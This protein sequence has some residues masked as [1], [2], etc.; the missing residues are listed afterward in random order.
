MRFKEVKKI[1]SESEQAEQLL[2]VNM[3]PSNLAKLASQIDARAGM[4]FEMIVPNAEGGDDSGEFEPDYDQ[5]ESVG[6]ID[7]A[8]NFFYDG[9]YNSR[10]DIDRLRES[11]LEDYMS[12]VYEKIEDDWGNNGF[13]FFT[14]YLQREDPF[15]DE[16][17]EEEARNELRAEYGDTLDDEDFEKMLFALVDEK[18]EAY[19]QTQWEDQGRNYDYAREEFESEK[20]DDYEQSD[21][22]DDQGY[23]AMS[24]ISDNYDIQWPHFTSVGGGGREV[25]DVADSFSRAIGRPV[26]SSTSYHGARRE[27]GTYVVEPDGSLSG[28]NSGDAGLEFVSPPL[29]LAELL[30]DLKKVKK[31][32]DSEGCY[33][34]ASNGTGLHINVSVPNLAKN[35]DNLDYVK[36]AL[37]LGDE[38]VLKEF[39][40]LGNTYCKSGLAIVKQNI[41]QKPED[42]KALLDQMKSNLEDLAS[43]SIHSGITNKFT[44][45]NTKDGY[46]E[47]RSPGGDWLNEK[48]DKI[49]PT[50]LRFV[51]ALDAA[52]K[53]DLYRQEYLK[54]LYKVLAPSGDKS[55]IEYF[56]K[57]VAG[58][59]PKAALRSFV[60]QAQLERKIKAGKAEGKMWWNVKYN[61]QRME[62]VATNKK[63]AK[64]VAAK[65]WGLTDAQA[66]S[67]SS[68]DVV[69]LRPYEDETQKQ[70]I[71]VAGRPNNPEGNWYLKNADTDKIFYRF[72]AINYQDAHTVLQQWKQE[73]PDS[74]INAVYGQGRDE[75]AGQEPAQAE[76]K[77]GIW[78]TRD[79]HWVENGNGLI[80][81]DNPYAV[82]EYMNNHNLTSVNY[83]M[84][85]IPSQQAQQTAVN[86]PPEGG[87]GEGLR[88]NWGFWMAN[89]GRFANWPGEGNGLRRFS[90]R[91]VAQQWLDDARAQN[92]RMR[93]DIEV[94]EIEP[95]EPIPGSTLDLQRQRAA[96]AQ[97]QTPAQGGGFTGEWKVVGPEGNEIYRFSGVGNNQSDANA[98]A[99]RWLQQNPR[100]LQ[101]GVE[102]LPVMG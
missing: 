9:D 20:Q 27:E 26:N 15:D 44:S 91:E 2:E 3:S 89:A 53:P 56:A 45:I 73:N 70:G 93:S 72:N 28:D 57:Y 58:E 102:V 51:V 6:D 97:Q 79:N 32:A 36:L 23:R 67:I 8:C 50:L 47:F 90:S 100:H 38:H 42:A 59:I 16:E 18:R 49:E 52:T 25:E 71:T 64:E 99:I 66:Q 10:R 41:K 96:A 92:P 33:T 35:L 1:I 82:R 60:R 24:D 22:L 84:R 7:D 80:A 81:Y 14:E 78:H 68:L 94:R 83:E 77:Y 87:T 31:W 95:A 69:A 29:P 65:E 5:D 88:G 98:V 21:W 63:E 62:V 101:G 55:T 39:E 11:M 75:P 54:K 86:T 40:R 85:P 4:E 48:F 74:T 37:L 13:E 34:G 76:Q 46:I 12:W 30:S 61:G 19:V 17:A 43:K